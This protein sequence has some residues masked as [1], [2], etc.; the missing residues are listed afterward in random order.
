[1]ELQ[2]F[3]TTPNFCIES[4]GLFLV[5]IGPIELLTPTEV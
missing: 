5:L 3:P 4:L 1:M 2:E